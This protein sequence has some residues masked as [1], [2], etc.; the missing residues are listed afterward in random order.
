MTIHE[1]ALRRSAAGPRCDRA[2]QEL[3]TELG[4][5]FVQEPDASGLFAVAVDAGSFDA[6][7]MRVHGAIAAIGADECFEF[8]EP[9]GHVPHDA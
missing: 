2:L 1:V 8:G 3:R 4:Q 6:A 9:S 5:G 7:V